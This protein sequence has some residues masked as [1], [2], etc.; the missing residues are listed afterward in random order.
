MVEKIKRL[1]IW[2]E[3][4]EMLLKK[5]K[6]VTPIKEISGVCIHH[7]NTKMKKINIPVSTLTD[8]ES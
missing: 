5:P 6:S 3:R 2:I 1:A 8:L 7:T 4:E